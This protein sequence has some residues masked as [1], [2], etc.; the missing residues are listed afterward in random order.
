EWE[1]SHLA[2]FEAIDKA[3]LTSKD[4]TVFLSKSGDVAWFSDITDWN[5]VIQNDSLDINNIRI[6]GVL[7]KRDAEWKIVQVHASVPQGQGE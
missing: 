3:K 2:Q 1:K 6:T 7:E 4:L 5:L